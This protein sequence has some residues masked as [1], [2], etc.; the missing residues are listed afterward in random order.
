MMSDSSVL[1]SIEGYYTAKIK[2]HGATPLGVDWNSA[3]GQEIRF[4]QLLAVIE[5]ADGEF[6]LNDFG[7]GYGGLL[8]LLAGRRDMFRYCGYD[9]SDAMIAE[10][11]KRHA[12]DRR[13]S[14]VSDEHELRTADFTLASGVFNVRLE[15]PD[16]VW[17]THVLATID[18]L[19]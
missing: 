8:D 17:H 18:K 6:S 5:E 13:A 12:D 11:R 9:I 3:H 1:E 7:C 4:E 2:A 19:V 15:L 16:E 10:A 14:F